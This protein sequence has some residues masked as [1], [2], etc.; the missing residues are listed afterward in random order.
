MGDIIKTLRGSYRWIFK[1]Y[2]AKGKEPEFSVNP[3]LTPEEAE[4]F[5]S[6]CNLIE[7]Q[8]VV[9]PKVGLETMFELK[10]LKGVTVSFGLFDPDSFHLKAIIHSGGLPAKV[11]RLLNNACIPIIELGNLDKVSFEL[12]KINVSNLKHSEQQFSR[13]YH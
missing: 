7:E 10:E 13:Y 5:Q 8:F 3:M 11:G 4:L 12:I 6:I 2:F 1:S 9:I